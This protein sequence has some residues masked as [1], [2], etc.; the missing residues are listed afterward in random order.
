MAFVERWSLW[1]DGHQWRFDCYKYFLFKI[2]SLSG[3]LWFVGSALQY[4]LEKVIHSVG[5]HCS[6]YFNFF[7]SRR[8]LTET[9]TELIS[10]KRFNDLVQ[11]QKKLDAEIDAQLSRQ[12]DDLRLEEEVWSKKTFV[13]YFQLAK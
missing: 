3:H 6:V 8:I 7:Y 11:Q 9:E 4:V 12:E 5:L 13:S 10:Q 1:W 2:I